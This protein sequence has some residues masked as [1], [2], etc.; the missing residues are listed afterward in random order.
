[1]Q[2][3]HM[4]SCVDSVT[5]HEA[6]VQSETREAVTTHHAQHMLSYVDAS[7]TQTQSQHMVSC[8]D[9]DTTG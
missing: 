5:R 4:M 7:E 2:S 3:L 8:V 9:S 6:C 1:M